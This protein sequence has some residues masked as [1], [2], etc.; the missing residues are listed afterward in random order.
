MPQ[1]KIIFG[2]AILVAFIVAVE[3]F[4]GWGALLTPWRD[5]SAA[6]LLIALTLTFISYVL[7][8]L[9]V[10]DYFRAELRGQF[11]LSLKLTLQHN[12]LNNFLPMRTGEISFPVLMGRYFHVPA[13][14]SVP[15]LLW[16]RLMDL[17]TLI[18]IALLATGGLWFNPSYVIP[19]AGLLLPL[20]LLVHLT[21]VRLA[22]TLAGAASGIRDKLA[23][24]LASLP[25]TLPEFLRAWG[26][27]WINWLLKLAVFAWVLLLFAPLPWSAGWL[28]AIAGDLTSVLPVHGI[29]GA[30]TYEAGIVAAL[31]PAGLSAEVA[32]RAAVNLHLFLLGSTILGGAVALMLPGQAKK[33]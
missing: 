33:V 9:R 27:T 1:I 14:R 30:G 6:T 11:L 24:A 4:V 19:L 13:A 8:T 20:P 25:Q 29:A 21:H 12:L 17:H 15:V 26:W 16:F 2:A 31:L 7:R 18:V 5:V 22:R 32:L 28:A 10:S 3:Y 23:Q